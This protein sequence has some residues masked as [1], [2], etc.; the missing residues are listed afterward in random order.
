M[1]QQLTRS[2]FAY[3]GLILLYILSIVLIGLPVFA[4]SYSLVFVPLFLVF[5]LVLV[6]HSNKNAKLL[7]FLIASGI[8]GFT[9]ELINFQQSWP[10]GSLHFGSNPDGSLNQ[11]PIVQ[12]GVWVF[13][14]YISGM[15]TQLFKFKSILW[16][17]LVHSILSVLLIRAVD[18]A[19][20]LWFIDPNELYRPYL[21]RFFVS[22][23]L[24]GLFIWLILPEENR[25]GGRVY[26][27]TI[28][29]CIGLTTILK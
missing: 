27:L 23:I 22:S 18:S 1:E 11:I 5:T 21:G 28:M 13:V 20:F 24:S 16:F 10:F 3:Y 12:G 17:A 7:A 9:A 6:F 8:V 26:I 2:D 29:F 14:A 4:T 25:L 19:S 15:A